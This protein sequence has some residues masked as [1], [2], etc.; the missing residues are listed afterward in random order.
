MR[1]LAAVIR[2]ELKRYFASPLAV[3]YLLSFLLLNGSFSLYF[4]GVFTQGEASLRGMF[5]FIPW[6]YLLFVSG[7]AM[8]LWAEE[9]KSKTVLQLITQPVSIS[10]YVWGKFIAAWGFCTLG[11]LLTFPF[12][13]TVNVLGNPDNGV[14]F[15]SYFGAFLLAGAMLAIA[16]TASAMS[17]NQVI[18]LVIAVILN[19]LFFLCGLEYVLGFLR[20]FCSDY[21]V[22]TVASFSFLTIAADFNSGLI[23]LNN[24]VFFVSLIIMCNFITTLIVSSKTLGVFPPLKITLKS[25]AV[26]AVTLSVIIFGGVN[27][28]SYNILS[29]YQADCTSEKLFT[30]SKSA[31]EVLKNISSPVTAKL[32]YSDILGIRDEAMRLNFN[33]LKQLLQKYHEIAGDNFKYRVYNTE[34]LSDEEDHALSAGLQGVQISDLNAAAY[35]GMELVNED[36]GKKVIP[37]FPLQRRN[38]LEQ[39]VIENVYLLEHKSLKLGIISGLPIMGEMV[40]NNVITQ[41]W[42]IV[43]ELEKYY[44]IKR[45]AKPEDLNKLDLLL[46][47][48]PQNMSA[49]LQNAIFNFSTRGGKVLAFFDVMPEALSLLNTANYNF[50]SSD[51]G[52]LPQRWGFHFYDDMVVTDL[53]NSTKI[54]VETADYAGDTQD[55]VQFYVTNNEMAQDL[56]EVAQL[57]RILV[58]SASVFMPLKDSLVYFVPLFQASKVSAVASADVVRKRLHPSEI[59]RNFKPDD[60]PK[61][62]AARIISQDTNKPFDIIV[63]GDT[64]MLYDTFWTTNVRIGKDWYNVPILDSANFVLN[65]L[66]VLSGDEKMLSL[67]GKTP[68]PRPY[69]WVELKNKQI[70]GEYKAKEK[71]IFDKIGEIKKNLAEIVSKKEFETRENFTADE[72][73]TIGQNRKE[74]YEQKQEL[75]AIRKQLNENMESLELWVKFFNIYALPLLIAIILLIRQRPMNCRNWN[76]RLKLNQQIAM[77]AVMAVAVMALG[78]WSYYMRKHDSIDEPHSQELFAELSSKINQV[79]EI[80]IKNHNDELVLQKENGIWRNKKQPQFL[81][82]QNRVKSFLS[83][84]LEARIYEKKSDRAEVMQDFGIRPLDDNKSSTVEITLR[85]KNKEQI[86][87]FAVGDYNVELSRGAVGAYV[88]LPDQFQV[89]LAKVDF[90]DLN[91]DYHD[92]SFANLWNLQL[93]RIG[94]INNSYDKDFIAKTLSILLNVKMTQTVRYIGYENLKMSLD[95]K[96]EYFDKLVMDFYEKDE[97]YYVHYYFEGIKNH[98]ILQ[99]FADEMTGYYEISKDDMEKISRAVEQK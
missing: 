90:V 65:A 43:K 69:T 50:M 46:M 68:R 51:Y 32:Y 16:Q 64:D 80:I 39:D 75:F 48:H 25:Q 26:A 63:V 9:F 55:L 99:K 62:L 40:G 31:V 7:I 84:L 28:W 2:G 89:W 94:S 30:P 53:A 47:V 57:K 86:L 70:L 23:K 83:E 14:I 91:P 35:F 12:V 29:L 45:V 72:L 44:D 73:L 21:F 5:D 77:L 19:L 54:T 93:G 85:N 56:P 18:S 97:K 74:L 4:G 33:N 13:I 38:L 6:I 10:T 79:S 92:W 20:G 1:K 96:G 59:I 95:M 42:Q 11:L 37:F 17:R 76:W 22:D 66:E 71:A 24:L 3:V 49:D 8:R 27:L 15:S 60:K 81:V 36:G 98:N 34:P 87:G 88:K 41:P 61:V 67:R 78:V 82:N 58:T 52:N